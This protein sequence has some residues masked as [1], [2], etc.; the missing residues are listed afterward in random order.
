V[1]E[2][3]D[4]DGPVVGETVVGDVDGWHVGETDG[5]LLGANVGFVVGS[6]LG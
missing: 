3:G 6:T 2:V 4:I 1:F 5:E